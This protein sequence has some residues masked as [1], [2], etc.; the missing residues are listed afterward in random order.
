M[1]TAT[2]YQRHAVDPTDTVDPPAGGNRYTTL[3]TWWAANKGSSTVAAWAKCYGGGDMGALTITVGDASY[4]PV[5]DYYTRVYTADGERHDGIKASGVGAYLTSTDDNGI[6]VRDH[7]YF[8][9]EGLRVSITSAVNAKSGIFVLSLGSVDSH[10]ARIDGCLVEVNGTAQNLRGIRSYGTSYKQNEVRRLYNNIVYMVSGGNYSDGIHCSC[11]SYG[12]SR[13]ENT[14]YVYNNSVSNTLAYGAGFVFYTSGT[15]GSGRFLNIHSSNNISSRGFG[16][17][18]YWARNT[19]DTNTHAIVQD[20]CISPDASAD[21][22][23]TIDGSNLV[24]Q[25]MADVWETP[26]ADL[27]LKTGSAAI[28]AGVNLYS[29]FQS[30]A[31][32]TDRRAGAAWDMGALTTALV[33]YYLYRGTGGISGVDF[34][35]EVGSVS[36][37][38]SSKTFAGL[39]HV[40]SERYTYVL[41][42]VR[43]LSDESLLVTPDMSCRVEFETDGSGDWLGN[44]PGS[45]EGV[46]AE[47]ISGGQIRLRWRYRTPYGGPQG[48]PNDFGIYYST[49]PN[50]TPGSPN[51]TESYTADGA[52]SKDIALSDGV[53]YYFAITA[54][55]ATPVE[56]HISDIIG[57]FIADDTAPSAPTLLTS[58]TF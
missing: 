29:T 42:P 23:E 37:P 54:R 14:H 28:D 19:G 36:G 39:V 25:T 32:G 58:T 57:P 45:V 41:R 40:A 56:S 12:A 16:R 1:A 2:S 5:E 31:V 46:S 48:T 10:E 22:W 33:T 27:H 26:A 34:S 6:Y 3:A 18:A 4:T 30:D 24:N 47:I 15:G 51:A 52:Y 8:R 55:D 13:I 7:P 53:A 21:D 35:T 44:R 50:I 38:A 17:P 9:V 20:Y 43:T 11:E 49:S